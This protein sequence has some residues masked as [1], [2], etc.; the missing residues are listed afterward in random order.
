[1]YEKKNNC[2]KT[3]LYLFLHDA[4][5]LGKKWLIV[6]IGEKIDGKTYIAI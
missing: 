2:K 4:P 6:V 1:M 3:I 5:L